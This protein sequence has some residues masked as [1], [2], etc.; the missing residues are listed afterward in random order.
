MQTLVAEFERDTGYEVTVSAASSGKL[1]AQIVHGAPYDV[2]FSA[3]QKMPKLLVEKDLAVSSSVYTYATGVLALWSNRDSV[4]DVET[5][6]TNGDFSRIAIANP[7]LAPFGQAAIE[8]LEYLDVEQGVEGKLV[9]GENVAQAF[10]FV[11]SQ[12]VDMGFVALS[13]VLAKN[14]KQTLTYWQ[15]PSHYHSPIRQDMVK[16]QKG[17]KNPIATLFINYIKSAEAKAIISNFGYMV[18]APL[19]AH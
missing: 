4:S 6:L 19:T 12:N 1:Y 8:V 9:M 13:Q 10:K 3:D 2:F 14:K 5:R 11:F 7:K 15:I 16:T 18:D 17:S